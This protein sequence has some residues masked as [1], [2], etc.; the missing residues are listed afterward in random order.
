MTLPRLV[1]GL[2]AVLFVAACTRA[3]LKQQPWRGG[4]PQTAEENQLCEIGRAWSD[5]VSV[6]H[7]NAEGR[8]VPGDVTDVQAFLDRDETTIRSALART[9]KPVHEYKLRGDCY[10]EAKKA[11]YPCIKRVDI[12][13]RDIGG[14]VRT[15]FDDPA[16]LALQECARAARKAWQ[17]QIGY[18][19]NNYT[20]ECVIVAR[21]VCP[22]PGADAAAAAE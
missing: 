11:W 8:Y 6:R 15:N 1:A 18:P 21:A 19:E 7:Q 13:M 22:L 5:R 4:P 17:E 3:D 2:L 14:L 20:Q 9:E 10:N 16:R 12:D